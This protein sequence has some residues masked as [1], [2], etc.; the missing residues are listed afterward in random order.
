M[1]R[2]VFVSL[3]GGV[4]FTV[5]SESPVLATPPSFAV[6]AEEETTNGTSGPFGFL[7]GIFRSGY[8]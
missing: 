2:A 3:L 7:T 6:P 8:L 4:V 1:R 5:L